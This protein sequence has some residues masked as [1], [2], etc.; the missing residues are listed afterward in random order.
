MSKIREVHQSMT[1]GEIRVEY[2]LK[3]REDKYDEECHGFHSMY[4]VDEIEKKVIYISIVL[5]NEEIEITKNLKSNQIDA[6]LNA[7]T[8]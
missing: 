2:I 8:P 1:L 6:I 5:P 7:I 3:Y 4:D